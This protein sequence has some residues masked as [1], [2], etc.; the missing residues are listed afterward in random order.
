MSPDQNQALQK[1]FSDFNGRLP[2][3]ELEI[4]LEAAFHQE[5]PDRARLDRRQLYSGEPLPGTQWVTQARIWAQKRISPGVPL[6]HLTQEQNFYGRYFEVGPEV[7]IPRPETEVLV[8]CVLSWLRSRAGTCIGADI[9][10]GSGV[11]AVTLILEAGP[12]LRMLATEASPESLR[13]AQDNARVL[14]VS[15]DAI[16]WLAVRNEDDV[17][18]PLVEW[19]GR[20]RRLLDFVVSN[21]PYLRRDPA[22]VDEQVERSE[23][24]LALFAPESDPLFYYREIARGARQFLKPGGMLFLEIPHERAEAIRALFGEGFEELRI[25]PDLAGKSRVLEAKLLPWTR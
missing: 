15:T 20:E 8:E 4:L 25:L 9:G 19:V 3:H 2:A 6:Q 1:F 18:G 12:D 23:P 24:A 11:I 13:R 14:G 21:P 5:F 22:E 17:V 16:S 7:L 10:T